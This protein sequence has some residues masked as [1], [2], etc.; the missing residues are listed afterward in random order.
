MYVKLLFL[1]V[2]LWCGLPTLMSAATLSD[3]NAVY[4]PIM[5]DDITTMIGLMPSEVTYPA[6]GSTINGTLHLKFSRATAVEK[7]FLKIFYANGKIERYNG[8]IGKNSFNMSFTLPKDGKYIDVELHSYILDKYFIKKYRLR[9]SIGVSEI[10]SHVN[11]GYLDSSTLTLKWSSGY[12]VSKRYIKI[13]TAG[14][15]GSNIFKGYVTGNT[16][17]I[18]G[19]PRDGER[20]Y[21]MFSS[22]IDGKWYHRYYRFY[23]TDV[24]EQAKK[25]VLGYLLNNVTTMRKIA[26]QRVI[27]KLKTKDTLV[28]QYFRNIK[29]Y[30]KL[31]YFHDYTAMVIAEMNDGKELKFYF[32]WDG[33]R[34]ILNSV[35]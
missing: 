9:Q 13:G 22:Y 3:K 14:Y 1:V 18:Y 5:M 7:R 27:D 32:S 30:Y 4:I 34:W 24:K 12:N 31:L 17:S 11:N 23:A 20:V 2:W 8:W 33:V 10:I 15:G 6:N 26:S 21:V 19:L 28:R 25:F 29:T 16:K 35:I